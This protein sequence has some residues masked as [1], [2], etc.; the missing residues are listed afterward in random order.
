MSST[1]VYMNEVAL[2]SME[3]YFESDE[4]TLLTIPIIAIVKSL[5]DIV[6]NF[7]GRRAVNCFLICNGAL[8]NDLGKAWFSLRHYVHKLPAKALQATS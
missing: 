2:V 7:S 1:P 8:C 6:L 3:V 4:N 5:R